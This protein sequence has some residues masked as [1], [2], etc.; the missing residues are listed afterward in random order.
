MMKNINLD[1]LGYE[2]I[3]SILIILII[4]GIASILLWL[5]HKK[6]IEKESNEIE[7]EIASQ[8][9]MGKGE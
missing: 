1:K 9:S 8:D 2:M 7:K 4:A 5:R 6:R 3:F